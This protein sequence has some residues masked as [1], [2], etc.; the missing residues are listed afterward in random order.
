MSIAEG[1]ATAEAAVG[2]LEELR[3][4]AIRPSQW[5][6][7]QS[8]DK[9]G[10]EELVASIRQHGVIEPIV[11]RHADGWLTEAPETGKQYEIVCGERRW[12]A[13]QAA[14]LETIPAIVRTDLDIDE[15][16]ARLLM[17]TENLLRHDLDPIEEAAA[18]RVSSKQLETCD[19][20]ALDALGNDCRRMH[21]LGEE[22]IAAE[23]RGKCEHFREPELCLNAECYRAKVKAKQEAAREAL[24]ENPPTGGVYTTDQLKGVNYRWLN[25][26][27]VGCRAD[28]EKRAVLTAAGGQHPICVDGECYNRLE[29]EDRKRAE[30]AAKQKIREQMAA[31][32]TEMDT[33]KVLPRVVAIVAQYALNYAPEKPV[34]AAFKRLGVNATHEKFYARLTAGRA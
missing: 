13:A 9:A 25:P 7:R 6:P 4:S 16:K 23:C 22:T 24:Q 33:T 2:K 12:R 10:L 19:H 28:C 14:G 27:P 26:A 3:V 34:A 17:L 5:N 8:F 15:Q 29:A 32:Q 21:E 18:G 31:L 30:D 11:V 20:Y 1:A